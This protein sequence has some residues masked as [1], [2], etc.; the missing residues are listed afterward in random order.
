MKKLKLDPETL[1]IQSF[2][3]GHVE[4]RGTVMGKETAIDDSCS[5]AG[6]YTCTYIN[7]DF[8]DSCAVQC[9]TLTGS[10]SACTDCGT[11]DC[12][13]NGGQVQ[14]WD[15]FNFCRPTQRPLHTCPSCLGTL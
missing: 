14:C 3:T 9:G 12:T 8:D 4:G 13:G 5:C 7:T 6:I 1:H 2:D 15:S 10:L 11:A